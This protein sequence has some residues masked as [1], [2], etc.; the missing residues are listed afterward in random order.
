MKKI[1][2][3]SFFM[4]L[5]LCAYAQNTLNIVVKNIETNEP[6]NGVTASVKGTSLV[7]TSDENG[8]I[9]LVNIPDGLQQINF[10]YIGFNEHIDTLEFPLKDKNVIE[11]FL[12]ESSEELDQ[13]II[14]STRSTRSIQ[15]I[16][17]RIEFIGSEEL[18]EKGNMKPGD[19]RMLLAESTGIHVQ[20]TSP[21][22][23]NASIRIQGLDGRY[24]QILK[25]GFPIYSGASSGLG[26]LQIPPLDLK[27]VE[28]IKGSASTLYGGGAIAG[29]VNLISKTPT[30]ERD[31]RFQI[32]GTSGRGLDINGFYGQRFNKIGTTIFASHN[33]N[34]AYDPANIGF[35][36]IPKFERYVLNPKL[37]VYFN[38]KTKMNFG[39]NTTIENRLGGDML[40]IKGKGDDIHQYFEKNKTQRYSTQFVLD[41]L[42]N[43][44]S[45]Y[46][47]KNSVSY[48]NRNITIPNY[49]FEG[50]QTAT[51]TEANYTNSTEKSEWVAGINIW[52][53]NFKEKQFTTFPLRDYNQRTFG[54]FIQNSWKS[55][56][57]LNLEAGFRTDYVVDYG[58]VFLPR[59]SALFQIA[60][61]LTSRIGGGFGYKTP[62]IFTEES[63]RI[64]YQNVLP[65]DD[66][67]NK[68][69]K[70]YGANADINYRIRIGEEWSFSIN[71][72]FFYTYLDNP[73][74]L[75]NPSANLYQFV[76]S[77]GY[78][79]TKG[80]ETNIKIGY[81]DLKLF[82]GYT[83]TDA[84]LN[85]NGTNTESPLTPKH[86]INSVLMYEIE[87][88]WKVGLEAYY[89]SPQKMN[90]GTTGEDYWTCGFMAEKIWE[91]FSLY[92]NF[93]NFL[94]TRQTRFDSIYTGTISNPVFKDIYAPLDGFVVNL[95]I[96]LKL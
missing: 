84:R 78:I 49:E 87:D 36:A 54:A 11:I 35:S 95:G 90:N 17:T 26:L 20:T 24:T 81:D 34:G 82:L 88:K 38:D 15:N 2:I 52:T 55:A 59:V 14:S 21:T 61:G 51:F 9:R 72:L 64:Q 30:E 18:A 92:A 40:Y 5:N 1:L 86:R 79:H 75:E 60:E 32:N 33:R 77:P 44:N 23:A 74:L 46:Q 73:L 70:S 67:T 29:L 47:I 42:I 50:T 91:R 94:D 96:K 69:E 37:F 10:S 62:T 12:Q 41:H 4:A 58:V 28:V 13:V 89:F 65:I 39:I 68:L 8:Q 93:E 48:F 71:Q 85:Q 3:V 43:E 6:L 19:I 31:L 45:S 27:Q 25:D 16:P 63:E 57:W 80:T 53:D 56:D 22:S 76:N 83:Y 7:A 66:K